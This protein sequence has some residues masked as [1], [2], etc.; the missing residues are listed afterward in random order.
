LH[1][2][3][4]FVL[5]FRGLTVQLF[6]FFVF[7]GRRKRKQSS[8]SQQCRELLYIHISPGKIQHSAA[9]VSF[10]SFVL[11][12]K[13][14]TKKQKKNREYER[15]VTVNLL[16]ANVNNTIT[17]A[18]FINYFPKTDTFLKRYIDNGP[19]YVK[20][21]N[22]NAERVTFETSFRAYFGCFLPFLSVK[23]FS[24][25]SKNQEKRRK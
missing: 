11:P 20:K 5:K 7:F 25:K 15:C 22:K 21:L 14:K 4:R 17:N 1:E 3:P 18:P 23:L 12:K 24:R 2:V 8:V 16:C 19:I 13:K 10:F 9:A 6:V